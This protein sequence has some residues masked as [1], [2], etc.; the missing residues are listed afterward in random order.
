MKNEPA[1][2]QINTQRN[3]F[4][5]GVQEL[6]ALGGLTKRELFAAIAMQGMVHDSRPA[7]TIAAIYAVEYADA[8]IAELEKADGKKA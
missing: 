8:L 7:A 5:G 1:F 2:P 6:S 4:E 3:S